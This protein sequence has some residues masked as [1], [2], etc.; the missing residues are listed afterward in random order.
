MQ[1]VDFDSLEEFMDFLPENER[2]I[3][4]LLRELILDTVDDVIEKLSYNVPFYSKH[5]MMLFIWPGSVSWGKTIKQGVEL[6][7]CRGVLL[8]D[9][10]GYLEKGDRKQVTIKRFKSKEDVDTEFVRSFIY[11]AVKIDEE[12]YREKAVKRRKK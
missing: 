4:E 10:S 11:D 8:P 12:L 6:G 1:N 3:V 5:Y 9:D 2:E 7:F